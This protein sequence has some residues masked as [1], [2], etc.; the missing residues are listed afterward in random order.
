MKSIKLVLMFLV[1]FAFACST[2]ESS[3]KIDTGTFFR[4]LESAPV[5]IAPKSELP[6]WLKEMIDLY[7]SGGENGIPVSSQFYQ[8]KCNKQVVYYIRIAAA[9]CPMCFFFLGNG[10]NIV[11][12]NGLEEVEKFL[13]K[14]KDWMLVYQTGTYP[15]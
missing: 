5:V 1:F 9:N 7:E 15:F 13:S 11:W 4:N 8:G 10:E 14:C 6:E 12:E 3:T 2:N